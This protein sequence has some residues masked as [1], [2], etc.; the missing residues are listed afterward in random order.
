M[1]VGIWSFL[2]LT[3][4]RIALLLI[5]VIVA[6]AAAVAAVRRQ[7]VHYKATAVVFLAQTLGAGST[8][9]SI[10]PIAAGYESA[11]SL[12]AVQQQAAQALR[13]SP[14]RLGTF[15][16]GHTSGD[17]NVS[18]TVDNTDPALASQVARQ[19]AVV[20]LTNVAAQ[21]V[22][23][24]QLVQQQA[25]AAFQAAQRDLTNYAQTTGIPDVDAALN[26][27]STQVLTLQTS[28]SSSR[29]LADAQARYSRLIGLQPQYDLLLGLRASAQQ[30]LSGAQS[31]LAAARSQSVAFTQ[32]GNVTIIGT[33]RVS[34]TTSLL[35]A[36][37]GAAVVAA[38]LV[39]LAMAGLESRRRRI[40]PAEAATARPS[41][42][43]N[44]GPAVE[45]DAVSADE[46][47]AAT[48]MAR[49]RRDPGV[50]PES[51]S[52]GSQT[53]IVR[54]SVPSTQAAR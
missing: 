33:E 46:R 4:R 21:D 7:P 18:L 12:P 27:A 31:S 39:L 26:A 51:L 20:G 40:F 6:A 1:R 29:A 9:Y 14:A 2:R 23:Q 24:N 47:T 22:R 53:E 11:L 17:P 36:G 44:P 43:R 50:Q 28:G 41:L 49:L 48:T 13:G 54:A 16:V 52:S 15:A 34:R 3:K 35:R 5:I 8:Q 30:N 38:L 37:V 25:V 19:L 45:P 10:D 42:A 32:P